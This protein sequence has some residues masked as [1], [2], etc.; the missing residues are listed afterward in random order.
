MVLIGR[1]KVIL[2]R[3]Q[4]V[5]CINREEQLLIYHDLT[6]H[7]K[8]PFLKTWTW[9]M[10]NPALQSSGHKHNLNFI[11]I[12]FFF[13]LI[14]YQNTTLT[15]HSLRN[16]PTINLMPFP[17]HSAFLAWLIFINFLICSTMGC[18]HHSVVSDS[19]QTPWTVAKQAPLSM[20][21]LRQEYWSGLPFPFTG[22][23]PN[24][25]IKPGSPAL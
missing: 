8:S 22:N 24:P 10:I 2:C 13:F 4:T 21:F 16:I 11:E 19:L 25:R 23:L 12:F 3:K 14:F 9:L 1:E 7:R 18:V 5:L 17:K 20:R 15:D 6:E